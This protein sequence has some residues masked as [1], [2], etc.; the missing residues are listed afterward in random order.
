MYRL[1]YV[2]SERMEPYSHIETQQNHPTTAIPYEH[3]Q[4]WSISS[5]TIAKLVCVAIIVWII[6]FSR[7]FS[8]SGLSSP[9]DGE[10]PSRC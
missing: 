3:T 8:Q 9:D 6:I 2:N 5:A 1:R 4:P 10:I 7:S